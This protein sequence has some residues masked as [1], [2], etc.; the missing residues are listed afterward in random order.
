MYVSYMLL[1]NLCIKSHLIWLCDNPQLW[2]V[3]QP[4]WRVKIHRISW[5]DS[6]DKD[7]LNNIYC[8]YFSRDVSLSS[9]VSNSS[10]K[11]TVAKRNKKINKLPLSSPLYSNSIHYTSIIIIIIPITYKFSLK[12]TAFLMSTHLG[13][14]L[15][16]SFWILGVCHTL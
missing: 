10:D 15:P 9:I 2:L 12:L 3:L 1:R 5:L 16:V 8:C 14:K 13:L 7:Q 4:K 11:K 6:Y